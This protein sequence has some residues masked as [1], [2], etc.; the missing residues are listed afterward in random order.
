MKR[1]I[2][3]LS[4][5]I[6]SQPVLADGNLGGSFPGA[7]SF[8]GVGVIGPT[9][10]DGHAIVTSPMSP[11]GQGAFPTDFNWNNG[12]GGDPGV[13]GIL[14]S[15]NSG[16]GTIVFPSGEGYLPTTSDGHGGSAGGT[17]G[18]QGGTSGG[19]KFLGQGLIEYNIDTTCEMSFSN[20]SCSGAGA[21]AGRLSGGSD[22]S[23]Q[24]FVPSQ[25]GQVEKLFE[26]LLDKELKENKHLANSSDF[27]PHI[28]SERPTTT[29]VGALNVSK[30]TISVVIPSEIFD[31]SLVGLWLTFDVAVEHQETSLGQEEY[32]KFVVDKSA[33]AKRSWFGLEKKAPLPHEVDQFK[34]P[35]ADVDARDQRIASLLTN[36]VANR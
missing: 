13:A 32:Y 1:A 27:V 21:I 28:S 10:T 15:E 8:G 22:L 31:S 9:K 7:G 14:G 4:T 35:P 26:E 34:E 33:L 12:Q 24:V 30:T 20:S 23:T 17:L 16:T 25:D 6:L 5:L 36:W 18:N 3:G 29:V 2:V 19:M 11:I